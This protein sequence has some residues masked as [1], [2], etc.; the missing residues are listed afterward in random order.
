[1]NS[2]TPSKAAPEA[3]TLLA[4]LL[5]LLR[6]RPLWSSIIQTQPDL[7]R[8][9]NRAKSLLDDAARAEGEQP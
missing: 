6:Q 5:F 8:I 7:L 4:E 9:V 1:M 2:Q 3:L